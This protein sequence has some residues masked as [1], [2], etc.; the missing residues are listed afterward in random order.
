MTILRKLSIDKDN[1]VSKVETT[2]K[3]AI[4]GARRYFYTYMSTDVTGPF[5]SDKVRDSAFNEATKVIKG[6]KGHLIHLLENACSDIFTTPADTTCVLVNNWVHKG[7]RRLQLRRTFLL[8]EDLP[9]LPKHISK[10]TNEDAV[11][12]FLKPLLPMEKKGDDILYPTTYAD[13]TPTSLFECI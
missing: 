8:R 11:W 1:R 4:E 2:L 13:C 5:L 7:L 9:P 6:C 3:A 10:T 12:D